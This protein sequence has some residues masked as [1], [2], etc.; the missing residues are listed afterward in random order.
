MPVSVTNR[1]VASENTV[2]LRLLYRTATL[3]AV[4]KTI[5]VQRLTFIRGFRRWIVQIGD[6]EL[7][8]VFIGLQELVV[9]FV[10]LQK[11][12][13]VLFL[14]FLTHVYAGNSGQDVARLLE[15]GL[16][17]VDPG[18]QLGLI[19]RLEAIKIER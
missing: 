13:I 4:L 10:L 14:L 1:S 3:V 2:T 17:L 18:R 5:R 6:I 11:L 16:E 12:Q 7:T 8:H 15:F 19:S 9:L